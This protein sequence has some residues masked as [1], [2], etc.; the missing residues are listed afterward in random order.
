M[1]IDD[2]LSVVYE[3]REIPKPL[4]IFVIIVA[5]GLSFFH[6]YTGLFGFLYPRLQRF[7]HLY[8]TLIISFSLYSPFKKARDKPRMID[9][10]LIIIVLLLGMVFFVNL[11]PERILE[12]GIKG[13]SNTEIIAGILL[14][15]FILEGTRRSVGLPLVIVAIFFLIYGLFGSYFPFLQHANY[16]LERIIEYEVWTLEGVFSIPLGV[17][18]T[19]VVLFIIMGSLLEELGASKFFIDLAQRIAGKSRGGPA[20][21]AVIASGI[22]GSVS[23]SA[24]S[25]VVTTGTFTIPLMKKIGYSPT[26]AAA[27]EA[28]ASTGGQ[29]MPPV[30]GAAAFVMAEFLNIPYWKVA[31][32][33]ALPAIL[34]Y[35][36]LGIMVHLEALKLNIKPFEA[37]QLKLSNIMLANIHLLPPLM[38]LVYYLFIVQASPMTAATYTILV[39]L[40]V[41]SINVIIREGRVPYREILKGLIKGAIHVAT[42]A[43]ACAT[44]GIIIG[45]IT[46]TGLGA[47]LGVLIPSLSHNNLLLAAILTMI[48]CIILGMGVPTTAAYIITVTFAGPPL[49]KLGVNPVATHLFVLY[50]AVLSFIT[51][52]VAISAYAASGIAGSDSMKTGF[53]AWRLGLTGFIVPFIFLFDNSLLLMGSESSMAI[54]FIRGVLGVLSLAVG[55]EGYIKKRLGIIERFIC[56]ISSIAILTP[57]NNLINILGVLGFGSVG[58][59][60]LRLK[61]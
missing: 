17:S 14:I 8:A 45:V 30:M 16:G 44:A 4:A 20:K 11:T 18:A 9:Y 25:N 35:L 32:A 53:L 40:F 1:S 21:V 54:G 52:P 7:I 34:Y 39:L 57:N 56:L 2:I 33:A 37:E 29:F 60:N 12:R 15:I 22:M 43:L 58:F 48:I 3:K 50:F 42:V 27:V 28:A 26:Y 55:L 6:L 47:R 61:S 36:S 41:S 5:L 59:L 19:Y 51:P 31:V 38:V 10:F 13:T 23:G 24:V 46:L 49:I